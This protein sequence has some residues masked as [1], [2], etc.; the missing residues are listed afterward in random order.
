MNY[1]F[2]IEHNNYNKKKKGT[3]IIQYKDTRLHLNCTEKVKIKTIKSKTDMMMT[4]INQQYLNK[5]DL[6]K[7]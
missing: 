7:Y 2:F 6:Q 1:H 5:I 3:G 4:K